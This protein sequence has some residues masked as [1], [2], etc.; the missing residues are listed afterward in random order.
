VGGGGRQR[1]WRVLLLGAAYTAAEGYY[2]YRGSELPMAGAIID[3]RN[4]RNGD[5]IRA[6]VEHVE[7]GGDLPIA[8]AQVFAG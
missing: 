5:V 8:A 4:T 7:D 3:V 6:R 1:R 2:E